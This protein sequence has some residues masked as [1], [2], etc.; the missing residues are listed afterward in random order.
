MQISISRYT[1]TTVLLVLVAGVVSWLLEATVGAL[2][3]EFFAFP[4]NLILMVLWLIAVVELY[5][6]R[7]KNVIARYL[8]SA[9]ATV[10]AIVFAAIGCL[11][12]GLQSEPATQSYIFVLMVLYVMSVVAMVTLRGWRVQGAVRWRFLVSHLGLLLALVAGFWG[13]ADYQELRMI[14]D[15]TP[16]QQA[17]YTD[18]TAKKL[19]YTLRL[20]EFDVQYNEAGV[21]EQYRADIEVDGNPVTLEVNDP[22]NVSFAQS[23]YLMNFERNDAATRLVVQIVYQPWRAVMVAG[24]VMLIVGALLMF[25]GGAKR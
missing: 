13:A 25:L 22:Y 23:I 24:I 18:G 21:P 3:I 15:D 9:Q 16:R 7:S 1:V 10:W 14:V 6:A 20:A 11:V 2:P 12:V 5:R 4:M 17:I 8:L 19:D